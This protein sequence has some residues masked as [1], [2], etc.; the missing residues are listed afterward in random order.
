MKYDF[1]TRV[2]RKGQ[3]SFKWEDMYAKK[4]NVADGI[5]P[6]SVADMRSEERRVGK[7]CRG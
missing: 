7:E 4:P 1:T 6:L 3:G 5:V 2:N